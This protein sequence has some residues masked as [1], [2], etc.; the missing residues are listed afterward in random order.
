MLEDTGVD[1]IAE[2]LVV[3][4]VT[5]KFGVFG[6]HIDDYLEQIGIALELSRVAVRI[7][8]SIDK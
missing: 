6:H 2:G 8:N 7:V 1:E 5:G 4:V 3:E